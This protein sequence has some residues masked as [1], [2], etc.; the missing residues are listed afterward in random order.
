MV[1][2][3]RTHDWFAH[4]AYPLEKMLAAGVTVA[5]G[6]DGRG[7]S[8]D[9]SLW[10]KCVLP[11][12][13]TRP[14]AST[15]F[16][17][18]ERCWAR[19]PWAGAARR[20]AGARQAGRPGDR[21]PARPRRRR[22]A[23]VALRFGRTGGRACY[24]RGAEL[25]CAE[26]FNRS[27]ETTEMVNPLCFPVPSCSIGAPLNLALDCWFLT[28]PTA[29]GKS[30]VGVEL[31]RRI[32]AE[33]VSLD[34]M[35]LYRGMDIGTAKPTPEERRSVPHHL[36]DVLEPHEEYSLAQYV[37]AAGRCAAEI[38]GRGRQV[39][40]VGGT[41]LYLKGLLR[42]IFEGRRPT[43]S[44][45]AGWPT[46]PGSTAASGCTSGWPRSIRRRPPDCTRTTP[47]GSSGRWRFTRRRAGRSAS[48][49]GSS[50]WAGRRRSA[51][52]SC[53]TGPRRNFTPGS[54]AAWTR[55]S[56]PDWS[57]RSAGCWLGPHPLSRTAR[58]A[59][60]Y[61]EVIEHLEGRRNLAETDRTGPAAHP[62]ACQAAMHVVPQPE[63]VPVR[64]RFRPVRRGGS[65]RTNRRAAG[66]VTPH[67]GGV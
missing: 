28:G 20:L 13:G 60:G 31:A 26:M 30:A 45:A 2:C 7:S 18:W 5:L 63:R 14:S 41:P 33:I 39:L 38:A 12:G 16:C 36:I 10:P 22:S 8:P 48:C 35:A 62:A 64:C 46:R 44:C 19:R 50:T 57:R 37:E 67:G 54:S 58:Q 25:P 40:F 17:K 52:C 43:G 4:G 53:S 15:A 34:S 42:G 49:S 21:G 66:R 3:P 56:P 51:A 1:Y 29:A 6:T 65:G 61:R 9:L 59:V 11:P 27:T 55:C 24:C 23:R 47:G 32:D